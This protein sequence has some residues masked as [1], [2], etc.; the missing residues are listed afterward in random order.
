MTPFPVKNRTNC[1][2]RRYRYPERLR[3]RLQRDTTIAAKPLS[4]GFSMPQVGHRWAS[5]VPQSP[6]KRLS[7]GFSFPHFEQRIG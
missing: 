6:Q 7:S 3:E 5:A 1:C 4:G 2:T